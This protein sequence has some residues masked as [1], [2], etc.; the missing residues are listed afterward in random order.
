MPPMIS[1]RADRFN[2]SSERWSSRKGNIFLISA[3]PQKRDSAD[4]PFILNCVCFHQVD[5]FGNS[6]CS[7]AEPGGIKLRSYINMYQ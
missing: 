2:T 6:C 1:Q 5:L 3:E 7:L 4:F